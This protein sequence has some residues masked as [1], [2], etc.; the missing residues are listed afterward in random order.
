MSSRRWFGPCAV[1]LVWCLVQAT[2]ARADARS[3]ALALESQINALEAGMPEV[4]GL[5]IAWPDLLHAFYAQRG[6]AQVWDRAGASTDLLRAIRA[7]H[8]DGLDPEDYYLTPLSTLA[9]EVARPE[10]GDSA[11][12]EFELL[13][14][15]AL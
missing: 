12:A 14:S 8:D 1:M 4:R 9:E 7:S 15:E 10:V 11:R 5:A 13:S 3:V 6:F 2:Q